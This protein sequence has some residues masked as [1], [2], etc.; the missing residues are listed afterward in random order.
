M[1]IGKEAIAVVGGLL[2]SNFAFRSK[3]KNLKTIFAGTNIL[4]V[5]MM[6]AN[7]FMN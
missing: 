4:A 7:I 3:P 6:I 2:V 5:L 1:Y